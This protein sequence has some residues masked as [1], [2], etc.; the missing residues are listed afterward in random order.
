MGVADIRPFSL[1]FQVGDRTLFTATLPVQ[2]HAV[3][4]GSLPAA[5]PTLP[6]SDQLPAAAAGLLFRA[7]PMS[8]GG[9]T[10]SRQGPW[11]RYVV[12]RYGRCSIDLRMGFEAYRGKFSSKTRSTLMRKQRKWIEH[13]GQPLRWQRYR[14]V[15][16]LR[17]FHPLAR[18][19]STRSY[20]ERLLDAGLPED[21]A[22]LAEM[23]TL[24]AA[25]SVRAYI[26]FEADKPVSYLYCPVERGVVIYAYLGYDPDY[27][28]HSVGTVLQWLALE[29]LFA[30]GRFTHFDFT[31]GETE[32]K[33]LFATHIEP[34][35]NVLFLRHSLRH[36]V[37]LTAHQA[38]DALVAKASGL[39]ERWGVK[40]RLRR[41]Q[42]FGRAAA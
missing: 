4:A 3:A 23:D 38:F 37:L 18:S 35:G 17:Q 40:A 24:A 14:S 9:T 16:E 5:A 10:L 36:Q 29:D 33:K 13:T 21:A 11:L 31:E 7:L 32:H 1:R 19:V 8:E 28:G 39:A 25:D 41:W 12:Q 27:L 6:S 20:Q 42:R 34:A 2:T 22:F 26:L 15:A 30:E